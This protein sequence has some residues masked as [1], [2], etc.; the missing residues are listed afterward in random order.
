MMTGSTKGNYLDR[1]NLISF[2]NIDP[3]TILSQLT[4]ISEEL[5]DTWTDTNTRHWDDKV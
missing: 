5:E 4:M 3:I 2:S 1:A